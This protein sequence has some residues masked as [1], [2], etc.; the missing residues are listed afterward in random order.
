MSYKPAVVAFDVETAYTDGTPA[1]EYYRPDF[2]VTSAAFAWRGE[3]GS[4][5]T[6][7]CEGELAT[8][9]ILDRIAMDGTPAV[10]HNAQFEYGVVKYRFPGLESVVQIDTMRLAQVAD[11]GGKLAQRY[12]P[13]PKTFEQQLDD[14]EG[15]EE[16]TTTGLGLQACVSRWLPEEYHNHKEPAYK[17][18]RENGVAAGKEGMNLQLLPPD[19]MKSYNVADAVV[20]LLLYETLNKL[21]HDQGYDP[22]LDHALYLSSAR[23]IAESKGRGAKVD[24]EKLEAYAWVVSGQVYEIER[25]FRAKYLKPIE[26]LEAEMR[27]AWVGALTS[28]RGRA[29]R[30]RKLEEKPA[31]VCFNVGST[32]QLA[33]LFTQK[34]GIT[35]KFWTEESK[36]SKSGRAANPDKAAFK[37]SPSLKAAHLGT[38]GEAGDMLV[39]RR[40]RLLVLKQCE[41]LLELSKLDGRWHVDLRAAGTVTG[42]MAGGSLG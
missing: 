24:R 10:V 38:Y 9:F 11:N 6:R 17:W 13:A 37:P 21:F 5:K 39:E 16:K 2:R 36:A 25:A 35:P 42:R 32:K 12:A 22:S 18:L 4:I 34:M 15:P 23:R 1:L 26:A 7:Y 19:L 27:E 3:D 28:E 8:K 41:S 20:T 14:L 31:L 29:E 33:A 40:K 30:R